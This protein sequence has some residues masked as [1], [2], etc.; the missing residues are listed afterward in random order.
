MCG[1]VGIHSLDGAKPIAPG[2]L[3]AMNDVITHRGPDSAGV[4]VDPGRVGLAHAAALDHRRRGRRPADRERGR[5]DPGRLQRRDLQLPRRCRAELEATGHRF[6]TRTDTEVIVHAYEE[7]GD[8][9][10]QR[11]Q[12]H[13]R[14]ALW[15]Y[16][17]RAAA[18]GA[19]PGRRSSSSSSR[20]AGGQLLFGSE[21]KALLAHPARR[22]PAPPG[23]GQP[24]PD[25]PLRARAAHHVRGDR[26]APR[27]P[28]ADRPSAAGSRSRPYWQLRYDVD[29]GDERRRRGATGCASTS[30]NAVRDC[31]VSDVPLGAFLSGG[32]D[33]GAVVALM[34]RVLA[35]P[36]QDLLD[37][38]RGRAARPSTSAAFARELAAR[39]GTDHHEFE[40]PPDVRAIAPAARP[41]VRPA[42]SP[43][44]PRFRPGT[45]A[46]SPA[47]T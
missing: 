15:D 39:Y 12:R 16:A 7:Y 1:I 45:C 13:V 40:M 22:A 30:T 47:A 4:Y 32:I 27:R 23:R 34:A 42:A 41:R 38:L 33:S 14:F 10:V 3:G 26:G 37:R 8:D 24:L 28:R 36:G 6:E 17:P 21:I 29:P 46:S 11:F 2:I 9:C 19:R 18:P 31:L 35:R 5:L 43:T 20:V 25:L 44:R